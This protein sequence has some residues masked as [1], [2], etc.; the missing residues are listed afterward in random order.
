VVADAGLRGGRALDER[1]HGW[2]R[3]GHVQRIAGNRAK[4]LRQALRRGGKHADLRRNALAAER[5]VRDTQTVGDAV[6]AMQFGEIAAHL[7]DLLAPLLHRNLVLIE[8]RQFA[9]GATG[10]AQ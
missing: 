2:P 3:P 8:R 7:R 10:G 4:A 6:H 5:A 9:D 1:D